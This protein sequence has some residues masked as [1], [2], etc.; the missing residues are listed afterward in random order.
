MSTRTI[1]TLLFSAILLPLCSLSLLSDPVPETPVPD[2]SDQREF[3]FENLPVA[4]E[5]ERRVVTLTGE[6][7][8]RT[9]IDRRRSAAPLSDDP[10]D[11][12]EMRTRA[13]LTIA[14]ASDV[15]GTLQLQD[16]RFFG[17]GG[18]TLNIGQLGDPHVHQAFLKIH[19]L[20]GTGA[21][22]KLGR[23]EINLGNQRLLGAVAWH[24]IGRVFDALR[25]DAGPENLPITL[26]ASRIDNESTVEGTPNGTEHLF[27]AWGKV[28]IGDA[29][30][31]L[32]YGLYDNDNG[33][34]PSGPDSGS[35]LM[36]RGTIG[37]QFNGE[38]GPLV[39]EIEGAWQGG[40][41]AFGID[42][43]QPTEGALLDLSAILA[44]ARIVLPVGDHSVGLLYTRLSGDDTS[45][46]DAVETFNTLYA[47]NHKFY[48]YMD[49]FPGSSG[50]RGLQ[51]IALL[52]TGKLSSSTKAKLESHYFLPEQSGDPFGIEIDAIVAH[53][54]NDFL[55]FTLGASVM[56]PDDGLAGLF[57][58]GENGY[59]GFLMATLKL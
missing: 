6:S 41:Q 4:E 27:G 38:V 9:Q 47:T 53:A 33:Q 25:I 12:Y 10:T 15:S 52:L 21:D 29:G 49:Y 24:P 3:D 44:S 14:P 17:D 46:A 55:T 59:W 23:Q 30:N 11:L 40:T 43:P 22:I 32:A 7:R 37:L 57:D 28:G 8:F 58:D 1:R 42:G 35:S 39:L 56:L 45:S 51:D 34:I 16:S 5:E 31:L 20:F 26:I 36:N 54:Y 13:M 48:G 50:P 19:D 18:R 2:T